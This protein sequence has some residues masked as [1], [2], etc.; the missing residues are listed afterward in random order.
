M[1]Y[2]NGKLFCSNRSST[3]KISYFLSDEILISGKVR[4]M[5]I[6]SQ[7]TIIISNEKDVV[8]IDQLTLKKNLII[9]FF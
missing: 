2:C 3:N 8:G 7:I 5:E 4:E 1:I 9:D 6:N